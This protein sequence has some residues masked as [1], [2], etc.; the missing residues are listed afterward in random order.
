VIHDITKYWEMGKSYGII[1]ANGCGKT[2][3]MR[4]F[5]GLEIPTKGEVIFF[6]KNIRSIPPIALSKKR[7]MLSQKSNVFGNPTAR[8]LIHIGRYNTA[9]EINIPNFLTDVL[10]INHLL[11]RPVNTLSGGEQQRVHFCRTV[12]QLMDSDNEFP[13]D[14][15]LILDEPFNHL[16]LKSR[17]IVIH[18]YRE[19]VLTGNLGLLIAHDLDIVNRCCDEILLL[20]SGRVY[21]EGEPSICLAEDMINDV[22][23]IKSISK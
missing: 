11:D 6:D 7:A 3:L 21:R 8:Q 14:K 16:D 19:F 1:G 4:V 17:K 13:K 10:E 12:F 22:F 5:A 9:K 23:D 2:T 18:V 15:V 20:K